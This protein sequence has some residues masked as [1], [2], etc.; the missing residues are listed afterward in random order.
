MSINIL[1]LSLLTFL[2]HFRILQSIVLCDHDLPEALLLLMP[3]FMARICERRKAG[4]T[5]CLWESELF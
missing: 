4:P 1:V 2:P 5:A 3:A